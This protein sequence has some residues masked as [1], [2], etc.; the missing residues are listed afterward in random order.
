[1]QS[2]PSFADSNLWT[3][4]GEWSN[5]VTDCAKWLNGRG[6]GARWDGTYPSASSVVHGT[7]SNYT[8]NYTTWTNQYLTFLRQCAAYIYHSNTIL[9]MTSHLRRYWEV[10][11]DV[12]ES[13]QGWVFWAWKVCRSFL[14][15]F[16]LF[17]FGGIVYPCTL[18]C[19]LPASLRLRKYHRRW[20][21]L[22]Q[23]NDKNITPPLTKSA[24][25]LR[26]PNEF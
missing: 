26:R 11:V 10:Q 16:S 21:G 12:G 3:V 18:F 6:I 2:L 15:S 23:A 24:G 4:L 19:H 25:F 20:S 1:M 7:C 17:L 9:L 22:G 5:A 8:G 14:L 13:V